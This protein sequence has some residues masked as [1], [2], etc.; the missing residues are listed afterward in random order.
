MCDILLTWYQVAF[1][2][3][4]LLVINYPWTQV[5]KIFGPIKIRIR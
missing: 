5:I 1:L 4:H 3:H 2:S